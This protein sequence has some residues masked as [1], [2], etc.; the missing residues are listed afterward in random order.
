MNNL[1]KN[2]KKKQHNTRK[3]IKL[4]KLKLINYKTKEITLLNNLK[5]RRRKNVAEKLLYN[6]KTFSNYILYI[7]NVQNIFIISIQ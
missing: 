2:K 1:P 3:I 5:G 6:L 7:N 4:C